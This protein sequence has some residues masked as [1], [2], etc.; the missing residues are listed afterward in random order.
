MS[1]L[2]AGSVAQQVGPYK[3]RRI[4]LGSCDAA[5][6]CT[7]TQRTTRSV[8]SGSASRLPAGSSSL[9]PQIGQ[10]TRTFCLIP[11]HT[12]Q[13]LTRNPFTVEDCWKTFF[14]ENLFRIRGG[15]SRGPFIHPY[16][17]PHTSHMQCKR[18][19]F[20]S[21]FHGWAGEIGH[22][23]SVGPRGPAS[24]VPHQ[25]APNVCTVTCKI[26]QVPQLHCS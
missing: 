18:A 1:L 23:R 12:R 15:G 10:I 7:G 14:S 9:P 21:C 4:Q 5:L 19:S 16:T 22:R 20:S 17:R 3:A 24:L 11:S 2:H 8:D 26:E 13:H 6:H 25:N